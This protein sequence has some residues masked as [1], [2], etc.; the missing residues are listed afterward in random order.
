MNGQP[1]TRLRVLH[2]IDSLARAGAEQSLVAVAPHL[3]SGGVDLHVAYLTERPDGLRPVLEATGAVVHPPPVEIGGRGTWLRRTSALVGDLRPD[4]VH[5]TLFESDLVGRLAA[6]RHG[7]PCIS[8]LVNVAYGREETR[9]LPRSRVRAAQAADVAT[10]RLV[11]G[12]HAI[13]H[14]VADVMSRR[15]LVPRARIEVI[16]RG[17]DRDLLGRRSAERTAAVRER[18]RVAPDAPLVLAV[19]RQERQKG[20]DVLLQ[21]AALLRE[22]HPGLVVLLAGRE[23]GQTEALHERRDRLGLHDVVRFLGVRDDVPD[24]LAAADV[25]AFP[26][27]WE[28]AGGTVLEAMALECPLVTSAL[29]A[30]R[31][32]VDST[33]ALL[34]PADDAFQVAAAVDTTLRDREAARARATRA[35]RRF[36]QDFTVDSAARRTVDLYDRVA[37]RRRGYASAVPGLRSRR[38]AD[39]SQNA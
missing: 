4:V 38:L 35:R 24:L 29:P 21:A 32:A 27:R 8:S 28:G 26:S 3:L 18:L 17:R 23:G 13:T 10:A 19:G 31:E 12:W 37:R 33:T 15:L 6:A 20:H 5:T 30:V 14:H 1:S 16:P 11:T 39:E 34:V 2:V 25:L 7:V 9:G 36:E 22:H